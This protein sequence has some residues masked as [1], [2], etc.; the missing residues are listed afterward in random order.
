M[1]SN[2]MVSG[3]TPTGSLA[4][5]PLL[6]NLDDEQREAA[7]S[8]IGPT[9]IVAG[10]GTGKTR[11]ITHR[12][13]Y[14]ITKGYYS[15]NRVLALTY[16][17]KAAAELR[18]RLRALGAGTVAAKTFHA[19]ALSQLEFFWPQFTGVDA[20]R[21]LE[22][23]TRLLAKLAEDRRMRID[24]AGL[25]DLAAEIEW[26]KFSMLSLTQYVAANRKP[27]AGLATPQLVELLTAYEDA[28]AAANQ[29]DW[30]DVLVLCLGLLR[31]EPRALAHV[32]QQY[33]FFTV[34]EYQDISPLQH[35][36]LDTWLGDRND[37][38]VVGDP[39][40]TIY[41]F[42]GATSSYLQTFNS[43]FENATVVE[44]TKNYRSSQQI[45]Q[46]ANRLRV[47]QTAL[48][49]LVSTGA[50]G[51]APRIQNFEATQDECSY[52]A[53]QIKRLL[54]SGVKAS[55]VAVLYRINGQSEPM[56]AALTAVGVEYQLKG[57]VRFFSRPE[58][59]NAMRTLRA[60]LV[61]KSEKPTHK[62]LDEI[63]RGLG[64]T[65]QQPA[66]SGAAREKWESLNALMGI[67]DEMPEGVST[68]DFYTELDERS[69]GQ[70]EPE[71]AA[72]TLATMHAAKGLEWEHVFIV[73]LVEG[74]LPISHAKTELEIAEEQRLFYVGV[75]RAKDT[76]MLTWAKQD[77]APQPGQQQR[78]REPSRFLKL[79]QPN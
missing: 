2:E 9:C 7:T 52:V 33:R 58:I 51:T 78:L 77:R 4:I 34:D 40:Q 55:Q 64:W 3:E 48:S 12:I 6:A 74:Y 56:E 14:G 26:R 30:E 32:H 68:A 75:T 38:C 62:L 31:S 71:R 36:L 19:A 66:V 22:S 21:V 10:A 1:A 28:K 18:T 67:L 57:G 70:H 54:D 72:V 8:L 73:G 76:L 20:P 15:A 5:D 69:R 49:P 29:I 27:P 47:S 41:S 39:N 61:G 60:E 45:V 53:A 79:L 63:C 24:A 37:L 46:S 44:L 50:V 42:T 25:R 35:A 16:T 43:R 17:N 23:K 59:Q 11:T 65:V 13:A